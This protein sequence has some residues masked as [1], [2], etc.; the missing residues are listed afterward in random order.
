M[1]HLLYIDDDLIDR[2]TLQRLVKKHPHIRCEA[3]STVAEADELLGTSYF[4]CIFTDFNLPDASLE[5]VEAIAGDIPMIVL[6]GAEIPTAIPYPA[7]LKPVS[8]E[9]LV[10]SLLRLCSQQENSHQI[11]LT[12]LNEIADGD[13]AFVEEIFDVFKREVPTEL[14]ALKQAVFSKNWEKA[15]FHVHKLRSRVRILGLGH[16][17][18]LSD[19]LEPMFK[20]QTDLV[21]AQKLARQFI[22]SLECVLI[23]LPQKQT[24]NH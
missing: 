9:K 21:T 24:S 16:L 8:S 15:A 4:D 18:K 12:Y 14:D 11:D 5:D 7:L 3:V 10:D 20:N 23:E 22:G 1:F 13:E 19:E 6:S 17:K 2:M